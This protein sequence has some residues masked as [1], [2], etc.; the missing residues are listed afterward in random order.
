MKVKITDIK[1]S[2]NDKLIELFPNLPPPYGKEVVQGHIRPC[3]FTEIYV[4]VTSRNK[5]YFENEGVITITYLQDRVDEVDALNKWDIINQAMD[6]KL[7]VNDRYINITNK[8]FSWTGKDNNILQIE[9]EISYMDSIDRKDTH[10]KM[11]KVELG[12]I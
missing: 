1:K 5:N 9:I 8:D 6:L 7:K 3:F 10:P 4:A 12:G 11:K 2:I